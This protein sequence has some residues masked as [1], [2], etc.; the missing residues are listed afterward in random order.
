MGSLGVKSNPI[1]R[2]GAQSTIFHTPPDGDR[3]EVEIWRAL[4]G[5]NSM[6]GKFAPCEET[7]KARQA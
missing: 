6:T 4:P 3:R 2:V 5:S 1:L 7:E